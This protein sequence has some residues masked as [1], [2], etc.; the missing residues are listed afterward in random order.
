MRKW[1]TIILTILLVL[2]CGVPVFA[3][4]ISDKAEITVN[5]KAEYNI[6]GEYPADLEDG[7]ATVTVDGD[8][9][10][11][12]TNA[13]K[14]AVRL[15]VIPIP[16]SEKEAWSW[17]TA[18]LKDKGTPIHTFDIYFADESGNRINADGAVV[19]ID[20]PHCT[21]K[22]M[23]CSLTTDGK[24]NELSNNARSVS[25]TFTTDGSPY[26]VMA[27]KAS[28][29]I[30]DD[31]HE[32]DVKDPTGGK[33]DISDKTPSTGDTVTI[34]PKPD[35]G[36]VVDKITVT[37]KNGN[38]IE[39]KD[40]GDGSYSYEQPDGDVTV[41]VT[42]KDKDTGTDDKPQTGDNSHLELWIAVAVISAAGIAV[43]IFFYFKRKKQEN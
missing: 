3:V 31:D 35:T 18:C 29:P 43:L 9:T 8:I 36:K 39:V 41:E 42:F 7:G 12:V 16:N 38:K 17:I 30:V 20:C 40:N 4:D 10:I 14:G 34:T 37:D 1:L 27:E 24:V 13:P 11:T 32:V 26:Y 23:V 2:S 5:A 19:T 25:V 33:V 6:E 21:A 15:I 28:A 22:P